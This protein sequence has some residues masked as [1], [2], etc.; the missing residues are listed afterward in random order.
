MP[1]RAMRNGQEDLFTSPGGGDT[2]PR[3]PIAQFLSNSLDSNAS[4]EDIDGENNRKCLR[5]PFVSEED[6]D[7]MMFIEGEPLSMLFTQNLDLNNDILNM[8]KPI[9]K[10]NWQHMSADSLNENYQSP[11]MTGKVNVAA[12]LKS[13][14]SPNTANGNMAAVQESSV[15]SDATLE[16]EE[17]E[18]GFEYTKLNNDVAESDDLCSHESI[19]PKEGRIGNARMYS[20]PKYS[21]DFA[22]NI[23][24][25]MLQ[26]Q[27]GGL[28][29]SLEVN[30]S[31]SVNA[32]PWSDSHSSYESGDSYHDTAYGHDSA[33]LWEGADEY[34]HMVSTTSGEE[35]QLAI[36]RLSTSCPKMD[37]LRCR[38]RHSYPP[39]QSSRHHG[40]T[41]VVDGF[42]N[43][44]LQHSVSYPVATMTTP[45]GY[46]LQAPL[47]GHK[48]RLRSRRREGKSRGRAKSEMGSKTPSPFN[49]KKSKSKSYEKLSSEIFARW[50]M[51]SSGFSKSHGNSS[52][53]NCSSLVEDGAQRSPPSV[54]RAHSFG[55]ADL[56]RKERPTVSRAHSMSSADRSSSSKNTKDTWKQRCIRSK[57][58]EKLSLRLQSASDDED[59][60]ANPEI[61]CPA[62]DSENEEEPKTPDTSKRVTF[63]EIAQR[64]KNMSL[65]VQPLIDSGEGKD[66]LDTGKHSDEGVFSGEWTEGGNEC[67]EKRRW[68][69]KEKKERLNSEGI[70]VDEEEEDDGI[71]ENA[72]GNE[73]A[74]EES[75]KLRRESLESEKSGEASGRSRL[76]SDPGPKKMNEVT[77]RDNHSK[78]RPLKARPHSLP[79]RPYALAF[80]LSGQMPRVRRV[81]KCPSL[82]TF[83]GMSRPLA[84]R[85]LSCS[86]YRSPAPPIQIMETQGKP[87]AAL[88]QFQGG[89][90]GS[91]NSHQ[92][93]PLA[94]QQP[95]KSADYQITHRHANAFG[96]QDNPSL[97]RS[98]GYHSNH[99]TPKWEFHGNLR[100]ERAVVKEK[101]QPLFRS[102]LD[103]HKRG[104]IKVSVVSPG[105]RGIPVTVSS[106]QLP[107]M[108]GWQKDG[109]AEEEMTSYVAIETPPDNIPLSPSCS[110]EFILVDL[111]RKKALV[112]AVNSA[113]DAILGHFGEAREP[114][115]KARLGNSSK[116]PNIGHLVLRY[117]CPAMLALVKDGLRPFLRNPIVGRVKNNVWN[118]VESS[119]QMGPA[120]KS[121]HKLFNHLSKTGQMWDI[122]MRFNAFVCGLLNLKAVELWLTH[123]QAR[124][125]IVQKHYI[126]EA[127]LTL[128]YTA[129]RQ[130][131]E[132]VVVIVQPLSL[133]P[134]AL[135]TQFEFNIKQEEMEREIGKQRLKE[136]AA[137]TSPRST[138]QMMTGKRIPRYQPS[139][140]MEEERQ[141]EQEEEVMV[142]DRQE[143]TPVAQDQTPK[144]EVDSAAGEDQQSTEQPKNQNWWFQLMNSTPVEAATDRKT[145]ETTSTVSEAGSEANPTTARSKLWLS[146]L[147]GAGPR[148]NQEARSKVNVT[149]T[150]EVK[151]EDQQKTLNGKKSRWASFSSSL[152]QA[153][154]RVLLPT[155]SRTPP[156][157][158]RQHHSNQTPPASPRQQHSNQ[159]QPSSPRQHHSNQTPHP[160]PRQQHS[161]QMTR[162]EE[163]L[164]QNH[165][166][167]GKRVVKALCH[168]LATEDGQ[169]SLAK[170]DILTVLRQVDDDWLLCCHGNK[171]GLVLT[172]CVNDLDLL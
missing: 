162:R 116:T 67:E 120:T 53:S 165:R 5:S 144:V 77:L 91:S 104:G 156:P 61:V 66:R 151:Q 99:V 14:P 89:G 10:D 136:E 166:K 6:L 138:F 27:N 36:H 111:R 19:P 108:K 23:A 9:V 15:T 43:G 33:F 70:E 118:V 161:N 142:I 85:S 158:P 106:Y 60:I 52:H 48:Y 146:N 73:V 113:V 105:N 25:E 35:F 1:V 124:Y 83:N 95:P 65:P 58:F 122:N 72:S 172:G 34:G 90:I 11:V 56:N 21:D 133:L 114:S 20:F 169:L 30:C 8:K 159:M 17:E 81:Q 75:L 121:L 126:P 131:F 119:T 155:T 26:R 87:L 97:P 150:Q 152:I 86:P 141:E 69:E 128:S 163:G 3:A 51:E 54:T 123:L 64:K 49:L 127:F 153:V 130:L 129:G 107:A 38:E 98:A 167:D 112:S 71:I 78:P 79:I 68:S 102:A 24:V 149:V 2:F 137:R 143:V 16:G 160:S 117:L 145:S 50:S 45:E 47:H 148:P 32:S 115:A 135:D 63:A 31:N 164:V 18:I 101:I 154:D 28:H 42:E 168:H 96:N 44:D 7:S 100:F 62:E 125:D 74:M 46:Y 110:G 41:V 103:V 80:P 13:H 170:G 82:K 39:C 139:R 37:R 109:D 4:Y 76:F 22:Q 40:Y 157:S 84:Q 94:H 29:S 171:T 93:F 57:S 134:F 55:S 147:I 59:F 12:M 140:R 88:R 92:F 132:D